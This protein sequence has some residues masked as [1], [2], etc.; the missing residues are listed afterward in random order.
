M[1]EWVE[2]VGGVAVVDWERKVV[3]QVRVQ[4]GACLVVPMTGLG[5]RGSRRGSPGVSW[6]R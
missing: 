5:P 4:R 3:T 6:I 1:D 2:F